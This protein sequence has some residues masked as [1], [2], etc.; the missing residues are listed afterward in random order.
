MNQ[1]Q[2]KQHIEKREFEL[3]EITFFW[4][5]F[6]KMEGL[7]KATVEDVQTKTGSRMAQ[8]E[9]SIRDHKKLLDGE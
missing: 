6:E 1:K 5:M 3:A 9:I 8:L 4:K 2:I 7:S